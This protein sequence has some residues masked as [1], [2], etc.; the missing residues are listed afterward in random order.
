VKVVVE[1]ADDLW[2]LHTLIDKGDRCTGD[3]EY[4][5]K[6]GGNDAKAQIVRKRVWVA[7]AVDKTEFSASTGHLRIGGKVTDGSEEVPRGSLHSLDI[8][9]GSRLSIEKER[10]LDYQLEKLEEALHSTRINTLLVLFDRETAIFALLKPNGYEMLL[11]LKGDVP[12]KGVDEGKIHSFYKDIAKHLEDFSSRF[13]IDTAIAAS[14]SFWKEYLEKELG[15]V[16]KKVI[17]TT[18]ST[19]DETAISEILKRPELEQALKS[20]RATRELKIIDTALAALAKDKLVYGV[21]DLLAAISEGNLGEV[22]V[23]EHTI[24]RK[25]ADDTFDDLE[26]LLRAAADV[27]AK[28]HLLSTDAA[29]KIDGFGGIVGIKRW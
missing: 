25:K 8:S 13:G 11:T 3:S 10:W 12:R 4:K 27:K 23:S 29:D 2:F 22:I 21:P 17:F 6:V 15:D 16:K 14:P 24:M 1:T 19:V 20:Q 26:M 9:E 7:L 18:V 5:Y 28:V